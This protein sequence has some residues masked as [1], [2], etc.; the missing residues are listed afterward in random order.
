[1]DNLDSHTYEIFEKDPLKYQE[2]EQVYNNSVNILLILWP[3]N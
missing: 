2:Y 3:N 1:M